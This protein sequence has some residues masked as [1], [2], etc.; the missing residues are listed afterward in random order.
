M[1]TKKKLT[2]KQA[3]ALAQE[4]DMFLRADD[5][6]LRRYVYVGLE[7]GG[8][9]RLPDA[10]IMDTGDYIAVF[11][12]HY[13][14]FVFEKDMIDTAYQYLSPFRGGSLHS[15]IK[16]QKLSSNTLNEFKQQMKKKGK[17]K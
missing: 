1:A 10:F 5:Q 9:F 14:F 11:T 17:S 15:N 13:K 2:Y 7:D 12:E 6:R 8:V 4:Y 3:F 16:F